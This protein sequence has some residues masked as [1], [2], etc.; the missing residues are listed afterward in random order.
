[1]WMPFHESAQWL[2]VVVVEGGNYLQFIS[3]RTRLG[4]H[5]WFAQDR[6]AKRSE[7]EDSNSGLPS[8]S[9]S[10]LSLLQ[11]HFLPLGLALGEG[12][13][14][15]PTQACVFMPSPG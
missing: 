3:K 7:K 10:F 8:L 12:Y 11:I 1:M 15:K 14:E 4:D 9:A 13:L 2:W 6:P 5:T